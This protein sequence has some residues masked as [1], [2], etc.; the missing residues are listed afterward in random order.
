MKNW[1]LESTG[2]TVLLHMGLFATVSA[3]VLFSERS[4]PPA[5]VPPLVPRHVAKQTPASAAGHQRALPSRL[6]A[7]RSGTRACSDGAMPQ[8]TRRGPSVACLP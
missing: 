8:A 4:A 7:D 1:N 5:T 3:I 2:T 6:L